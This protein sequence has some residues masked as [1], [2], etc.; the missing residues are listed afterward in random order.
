MDKI[1]T[2]APNLY[3]HNARQEVDM[4]LCCLIYVF[5]NAY[6]IGKYPFLYNTIPEQRYTS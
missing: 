2:R 5:E 6:V 4:V 1:K 3:L